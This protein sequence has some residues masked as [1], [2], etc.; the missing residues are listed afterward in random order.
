MSGPLTPKTGTSSA[1]ATREPSS[2][3]GFVLTGDVRM[4]PKVGNTERG[5]QQKADVF[6]L[7]IFIYSPATGNWQFEVEDGS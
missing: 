7:E 1:G 4:A 2:R 6:G 5:F 3:W